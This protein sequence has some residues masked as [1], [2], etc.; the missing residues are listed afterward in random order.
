MIL[1]KTFYSLFLAT[2]IILLFPKNIH[3]AYDFD[4]WPDDISENQEVMGTIYMNAEKLD[5]DILKLC[6]Y[7]KEIQQPTLGIAFHLIYENE[8]LLFLNYLP[9]SYLERA[10]DPFYLV[11][12]SQKGEIIYGETL[13]HGDDFPTGKGQIACINFQILQGSKFNFNFTNGVIS[14]MDTVRQDLEKIEWQNLIFDKELGN[15]IIRNSDFLEYAESTVNKQ[16]FSDNNPLI[17]A[18]IMGFLGLVIGL[19]FTIT[20]LK[21]RSKKSVNFK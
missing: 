4:D 1:K 10:G 3:A 8:K 17:I 21:K 9:G 12:E 16:K 11:N 2:L 5:G 15:Q 14:T 13:R 18:L 6:I 20:M 19:I 7:G